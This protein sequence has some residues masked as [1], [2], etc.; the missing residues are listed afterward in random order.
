MT[1]TDG[2]LEVEVELDDDALNVRWEPVGAREVDIG[3][4]PTPDPAAHTHVLRVPV[5]ERLV[6]LADPPAGR[7]YVSVSH[8]G[9][10]VVAAERRLHFQG[11][12]NFRDLGGYPTISGGR[13]RWGQV[14]RS[15]ALHELTDGDLAAF[16]GLGIRA[17]YD[18]RGE[19]EYA[20]EPGPRPSRNLPM[21]ARF[22]ETPDLSPLRER[23]DGEQ[24]LFDDYRVMVAEGGS[25]FGGVLSGLAETDGAPAVIHCAGGKDR[26]GLTVAMLLS[27]LGVDRETI[28]DD[29]QLTMRYLPV[30]SMSAF[31]DEMEELGIGRPAAEA[32]LGTPRWVMAET[33]DL[34]DTEHGGIEAYL[35]GGAS[36]STEAL[37]ELRMR[38][39]G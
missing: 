11:G 1:I 13:I 19:K 23:S 5:G 3:W 32:L 28:L 9:T 29:Y 26:S 4:G 30:E 38:F 25:V 39:V 27:W 6:R 33:L 18:V 34:V 7:T 31:V 15:G 14:F 10:V 12:P 2:A 22:S 36:M 21:P 37:D 16:D 17:I 8:D 35:R 24:W 20:E